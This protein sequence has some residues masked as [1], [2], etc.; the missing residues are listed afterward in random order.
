MKY[1]TPELHVRLQADGP[2]AMDA[3]DAEW[4][5]ALAK[6]QRRLKS[7][8]P[9]L[10]ASACEFLDEA[11][12]HDAEVLWMGQ[13]GTFFG[14]LLRLDPPS[15]AALGLYYSGAR[16]VHFDREAIP[17]EFSGARM[18]WMYDEVDVGAEDGSFRHS[19]LFGD[20]SLLELEAREV[21]VTSLDTIY[22]QFDSLRV[23]ASA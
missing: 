21:H 4:E 3:A 6:Y 13:S 20:G 19:V 8:R 2:R 7:I 18:L 17:R 23:A 5:Q 16:D 22:A 14:V 9:K 11:R 15:I 1:F 12:L 10:P